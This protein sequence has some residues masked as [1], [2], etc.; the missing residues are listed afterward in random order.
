MGSVARVLVAFAGG[1]ALLC[2]GVVWNAPGANVLGAPTL[3]GKWITC[4]DPSSG[5]L[6]LL[7]TATGKLRRLTEKGPAASKEYAYFSVPSRDGAQVAYAWF[8]DGGF[9]DLRVDGR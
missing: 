7:E 4:V 2:A 5:D 9:Y 8:N 1:A 6:A 3:D